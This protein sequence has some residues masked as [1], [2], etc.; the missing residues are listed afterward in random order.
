VSWSEGFAEGFADELEKLAGL[1]EAGEAESAR[2]G[3]GN[4]LREAGAAEGARVRPGALRRFGRIAVPAAV[5]ASAAALLAHRLRKKREKTAGIGSLVGDA[6]APVG[7]FVVK[8][9]M[10][11][12]LGLATPAMAAGTAYA[13]GLSG[14]DKE[15]ALQ[16]SVGH[17]SAYSDV[18][19]HNLIPE[20]APPW[21]RYRLSRNY[22]SWRKGI[23]AAAK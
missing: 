19:F 16:A 17:P 22:P 13:G 1:R 18:N 6:L 9:P 8:H 15:P 3:P 10:A 4:L 11:T 12:L 14:G 5:G 20:K 21:E 23:G 2:S 7:K